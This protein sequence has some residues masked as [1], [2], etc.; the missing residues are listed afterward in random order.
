MEPKR[1]EGQSALFRSST[2]GLRSKAL[3]S[4]RLDP[5]RSWEG[6]VKLIHAN[7]LKVI[8]SRKQEGA[9][10]SRNFKN[11]ASG[12]SKRTSN[13]CWVWPSAKWISAG[14]SS[15]VR[16]EIPVSMTGQSS[17]PTVQAVRCVFLSTTPWISWD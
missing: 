8:P 15:S 5:P 3:P 11:Y 4:L 17:P 16:L 6:E 9:R 12:S 2:F 14:A 7:S 13:H 10:D 1:G